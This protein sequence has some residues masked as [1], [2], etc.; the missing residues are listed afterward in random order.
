M[1]AKGGRAKRVGSK[2]SVPRHGRARASRASVEEKVIETRE[3]RRGRREIRE[4]L[5]G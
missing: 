4:Q 1:S 2:A 3:R 5:Q